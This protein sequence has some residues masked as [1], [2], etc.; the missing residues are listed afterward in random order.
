MTSSAI[1]DYLGNLPNPPNIYPHQK[2]AIDWMK[3]R[4]DLKEPVLLGDSMG[5]G[6]T[7]DICMLL[8]LIR[9]QKALIVVPTST[10]YQWV[11]ALL[12]YCPNYY[13]YVN[14]NHKI[15][16]VILS[17]DGK[18][19]HSDYGHISILNQ[20]NHCK[21]TVCNYHSVTPFPGIPT[22][23]GV[24]GNKQEVQKDWINIFQK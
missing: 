2:D 23:G 4:W 15:R 9:V 13:V 6:K 8:E 7:I 3:Y 12:T 20:V 18:I 14:T 21:V 19:I 22:L 11:R 1:D 10:I 24:T 16:Q 5:L 17:A